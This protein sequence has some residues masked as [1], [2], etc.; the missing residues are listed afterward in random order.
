MKNQ[1]NY[2][3]NLKENISML[4]E[5]LSWLNRSYAKCIEIGIKENYSEDEFDIFETL[6]SR[7]ARVTDVLIQKVFRS[8]DAVEF[9]SGGTMIDLIN[10][11]H[12]RGLFE[13]IDEIRKI[14]DLRNDIAH[15]YV[16]YD[17]K[18]VFSETFYFTPKLLDIVKNTKEYC[19]KYL[20]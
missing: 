11:T 16:L 13:S 14:K 17:I 18:S 20:I 8:I 3:A 12:K 10:R 1:K 5:S 15:E 7:Y 4:D 6:T 19:K 9:E 2:I